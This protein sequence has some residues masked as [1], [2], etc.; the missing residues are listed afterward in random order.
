MNDAKTIHGNG[1][2]NDAAEAPDRPEDLPNLLTATGDQED[3]LA[4]MRGNP[5]YAEL[6]REL[7]IIAQAAHDIL[8]PSVS[9]PSEKVWDN[10]ASNLGTK[11]E[12]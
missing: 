11:A 7:E 8:L 10:I 1:R 5:D 4:A 2:L 6:I 12:S 3:P 9:E